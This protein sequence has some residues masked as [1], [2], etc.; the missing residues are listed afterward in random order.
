MLL[1]L[2]RQPTALQCENWFES[3]QLGSLDHTAAI[4]SEGHWHL[5]HIS[6][7]SN[8]I[9]LEESVQSP[10]A[11]YDLLQPVLDMGI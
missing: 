1:T 9:C 10:A 5:M 11:H 4:N 8:P 2:A 7:I 6:I 3:L